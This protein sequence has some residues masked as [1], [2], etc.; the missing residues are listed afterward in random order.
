MEQI[1]IQVHEL[2]ADVTGPVLV[3]MLP[4]QIQGSAAMQLGHSAVC[5]ETFWSQPTWTSSAD[6][7]SCE[8]VSDLYAHFSCFQHQRTVQSLPN[9]SHSTVIR[10]SS[11]KILFA[12]GSNGPFLCGKETTFEGGM[13][14][15]AIAW[16]PGRIPAG[17]VWVSV[18]ADFSV[19]S[20]NIVPI[21][22]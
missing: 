15:P 16:W 10:F 18:G 2:C 1:Q 6:C 7:G 5:S 8:S 9:I 11:V 22:P 12:G 21:S 13:R 14:E 20:R 17:T 4:A 3:L 19:V